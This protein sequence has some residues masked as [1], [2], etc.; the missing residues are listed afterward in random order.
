MLTRDQDTYFPSVN[1]RAKVE[2]PELSDLLIL[3][4]TSWAPLSIHLVESKG[5][6]LLRTE[7]FRWHG[8][9][10]IGHFQGMGT[11][12]CGLG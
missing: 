8:I 4:L 3:L 2:N 7:T 5:V 10:F 1:K 11:L 9:L 12:G 6:L